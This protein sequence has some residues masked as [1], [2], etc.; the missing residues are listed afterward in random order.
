MELALAHPMKGMNMEMEFS[1]LLLLQPQDACKA[2][3]NILVED[4]S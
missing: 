4:D 1:Q 3:G 2:V